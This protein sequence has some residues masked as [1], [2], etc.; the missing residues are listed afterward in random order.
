[1]CYIGNNDVFGLGQGMALL[2]LT[3]MESQQIELELFEFVLMTHNTTNM[4]A[5]Q[6]HVAVSSVSR[7]QSGKRYVSRRAY[8]KVKQYL[9]NH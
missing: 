8:R 1:M 2:R 3:E 6:S 5:K 4:I 7:L 9:Q